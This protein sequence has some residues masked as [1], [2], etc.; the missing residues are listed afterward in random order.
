MSLVLR[1]ALATF[2]FVRKTDARPLRAA[3][4]AASSGGLIALLFV[5]FESRLLL[6]GHVVRFDTRFVT[7]TEPG[8]LKRSE[9]GWQLENPDLA[10][11]IADL[12]L[13]SEVLQNAERASFASAVEQERIRSQKK[14]NSQSIVQMEIRLDKLRL[15][16]GAEIW[17]DLS[18]PQQ[19]GAWVIPAGQAIGAVSE[20]IRGH[21]RLSFAE[22]ALVRDAEI[23]S[24]TALD[25]RPVHAPDCVFM[26]APGRDAAG[27]IAINGTVTII[28]HPSA[29]TN[30]CFADL[31]HGEPVVARAAMPEMSL[32]GRAWLRLTRALQERLPL[33]QL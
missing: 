27:A 8:V 3:M 4:V 13:Y 6:N 28:A 24:E 30:A 12:K 19:A 7:A 16:Q 20:S 10:F 2:R 5:P 9:D 25:I 29:D 21:I 26:A 32:A 33:E 23:T 1:P 15:E 18:A 14:A 11:Q 31:E 22:A 17:T